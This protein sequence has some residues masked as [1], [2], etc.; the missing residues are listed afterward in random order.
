MASSP[1]R[2]AI[3][4]ADTPI[5][6]TRA[7]Y[8]SYGAVFTSLLYKA[9]AASHVPTDRLEITAWDVINSEGLKEGELEDM[10]GEMKT[11][12]R[13]GYPRLD[14][15][16]AILITGSRMWAPSSSNDFQAV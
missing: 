7:K 12:R 9:A 4:E 2:I 5:G 14:D 13:K 15:I 8:G 1:L 3:L 16:D 10:G 11:Q 6:T